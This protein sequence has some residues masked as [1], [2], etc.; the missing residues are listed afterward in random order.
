VESSVLGQYLSV[1][2]EI[3]RLDPRSKLI[4]SVFLM[5]SAVLGGWAVLVLNAVIVCTGLLIG[6]MN[7]NILWLQLKPLWLIAAITGL[8]QILMTPGEA[9]FQAGP[10]IISKTGLLA[11]LELF[12]RLTVFILIGVLLTATTSAL[13]LA[14]GLEKLFRP[15]GKIGLPV[16]DII[17]AAVIAVRFIPVIFEEARI[18]AGAQVSRGAGFYGSSPAKRG[19][20]VIALLVPLLAGT[21]R[22]SGDLATAMEARC[23]R[24]NASRTRL[25]NLVFS[26]GDVICLLVTGI[27]PVATAVTRMMS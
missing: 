4:S 26:A 3:H 11:G 15:L 24:G 22:R 20:A 16:D 25:K 13:S 12:F 2:S 1:E 7:F 8:L 17:M 18:I 14:S 10:L 27:T 21:L 9:L 19:I 5:V 23:Y 6:R